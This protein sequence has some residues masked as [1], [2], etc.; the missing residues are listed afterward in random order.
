MAPHVTIVG[1][2]LG[3]LVLA[4]VL[5]LH[6]FPV[7]IYEAEPSA[8]ARRQGGLLDIHE[9]TGQVALAAAGLSDAFAGLIHEGGQASRVL[10]RHGTLLFDEPDDGADMARFLVI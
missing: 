9:D 4:R 1:A 6:G 2:G 10:D 7:S 5:H 3:G 8:E